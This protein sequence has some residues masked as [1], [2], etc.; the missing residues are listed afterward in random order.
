MEL[1]IGSRARV[2]LSDLH[3][4]LHVRTKRLAERLIGRQTCFIRG[5][6]VELRETITLFVRNIQIPVYIDDVLKTQLVSETLWPAEG[7]G[8]EPRQV[9]HMVRFAF[10]E[11]HLQHRVVQNLIV[12]YLFEAVQRCIAAGMFVKTFQIDTLYDHNGNFVQIIREM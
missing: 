2:L 9:F 3:A 12:E 1:G 11:Q 5:L 7:F 10:A 8:S 4:K 6:H